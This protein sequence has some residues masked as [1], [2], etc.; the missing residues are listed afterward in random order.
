MKKIITILLIVVS[1]A[2]A[3]TTIVNGVIVVFRNDG[4]WDAAGA[5]INNTG[6]DD[7]TVRGDSI[8]FWRKNGILKFSGKIIEGGYWSDNKEFF[9]FG[10]DIGEPTILFD[11]HCY[12]STGMKPV[13]RTSKIKMCE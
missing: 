7:Y 1:F 9:I 12:D 2:M 8:F 4:G 6:I 11:G 13:K 5:A 10:Q 3:K